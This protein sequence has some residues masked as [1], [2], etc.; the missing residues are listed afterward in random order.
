MHKTWFPEQPLK[1]YE[2]FLGNLILTFWYWFG[3]VE[4][5]ASRASRENTE[6]LTFWSF[7]PRIWESLKK[8][9]KEKKADLKCNV[10]SCISKFFKHL[11]SYVQGCDCCWLSSLYG[12]GLL[13]VL[14]LFPLLKTNIFKSQFKLEKTKASWLMSFVVKRC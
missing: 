11:C 4:M 13:L 1:H 10:W 9:R 3:C 14:Q 6:H 12:K 7:I 2:K 8:K 5:F